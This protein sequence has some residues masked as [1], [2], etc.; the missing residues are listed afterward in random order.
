MNDA[1]A[2]VPLGRHRL[3][4]N[5]T[6]WQTLDVSTDFFLQKFRFQVYPH[7]DMHPYT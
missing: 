4:R 1:D 2:R 5:V 6:S 7:R 3:H